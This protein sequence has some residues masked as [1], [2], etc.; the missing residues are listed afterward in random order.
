MEIDRDAA[1]TLRLNRPK[2]NVHEGDV[3]EIDGKKY[4]RIDLLAGGVPCPPFSA[5]GKQLASLTQVG[6]HL[7]FSATTVL[8]RIRAAGRTTRNSTQR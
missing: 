2:W 4:R 5:A 3:R 6:E 1:A 7:G 8:H